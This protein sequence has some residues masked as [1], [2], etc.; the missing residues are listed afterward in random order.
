MVSQAENHAARLHLIKNYMG[1]LTHKDRHLVIADQ[2][3]KGRDAA[4]RAVRILYA[5]TPLTWRDLRAYA[6]AGRKRLTVTTDE[7]GRHIWSIAQY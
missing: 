6:V 7:N 2:G 4:R 3:T 5:K 1:M